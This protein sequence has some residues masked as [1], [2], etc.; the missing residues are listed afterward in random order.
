LTKRSSARFEDLVKL[1]SNGEFSDIESETEIL[2]KIQTEIKY[3]GYIARQK[4]EI[5]YLAEN[6][7]RLIPK[8]F[9]Y[10]KVISISNEAREKLTKIR[11]ASLGQASRIAGVSAADI[12]VLT[13]FLKS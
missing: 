10:S 3:E 6:E 1:A 9:D 11:P 8:D 13:V 2:T 5:E 7:S 12:S 4:R